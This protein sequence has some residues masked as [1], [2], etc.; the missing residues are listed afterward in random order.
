MKISFWGMV[1]ES[2]RSI[3][4]ALV[5]A[6]PDANGPRFADV[7]RAVDARGHEGIGTPI[8]DFGA[9]IGR[10]FDFQI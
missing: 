1:R 2:L 6:R 8:T 4:Q 10:R 9:A 7:V 3:R 5:A